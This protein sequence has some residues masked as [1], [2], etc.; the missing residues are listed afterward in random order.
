MRMMS[1][2]V[3]CHHVSEYVFFFVCKLSLSRCAKE[4]NNRRL[5]FLTIKSK[6]LTSWL[7]LYKEFMVSIYRLQSIAL[8]ES[9]SQS[10][11]QN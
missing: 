6:Q 2:N 7:I 5:L 11:F 3:H 1:G 4:A 9:M 8:T 10:L